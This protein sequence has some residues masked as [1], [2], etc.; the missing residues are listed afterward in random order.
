[1]PTFSAKSR[2]RLDTCH[3]EL[4]RLFDA[5]VKVIDCTVIEGYRSNA[6]QEEAFR[7]GTSQLR[8]GQSL[9]NRRPSL[10]VDVAPYPIDW[11]DWH[12]WYFF[13]GYVLATARSMGME[14]RS[15]LDWNMNFDFKDQSFFDAPHFELLRAANSPSLIVVEAE[16]GE[17]GSEGT[18]V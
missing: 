10:A 11:K 3:P 7:N 4:I 13:A 12:R 17:P 15:G 1:M 16:P 6:D 8:P 2:Q 18:G 5:V 9:H 14:V